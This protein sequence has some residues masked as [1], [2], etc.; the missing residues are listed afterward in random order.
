MEFFKKGR[1]KNNIRTSNFYKTTSEHHQTSEHQNIINI[2]TSNS[3][4]TTSE[5]HQTFIIV[6]KEGNIERMK[7]TTL[8]R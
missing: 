6:E 3:Y 5:H 7:L 8:Q 2:R 4:K 1:S